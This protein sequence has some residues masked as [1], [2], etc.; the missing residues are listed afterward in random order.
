MAEERKTLADSIKEIFQDLVQD[1]IK[2]VNFVFRLHRTF[3]VLLC[4]IFGIVL[5]IAQVR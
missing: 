5:S 2:T 3:T 4:L 1:E